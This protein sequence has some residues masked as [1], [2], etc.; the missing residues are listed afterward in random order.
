MPL[1]LLV[2]AA[3]LP[4]AQALGQTLRAAGLRIAGE[5]SCHMLVRDAVR[6]A[7]EAVAVLADTQD[8]T[9]HQAV[10]LLAGTA[11]LPVLLLGAQRLPSRPEVLAAIHG[12]LPGEADAPT[13]CDALRWADARFGEVQRLR[14]E[15]EGV[16]TRFNERKWV[17]RAKWLLLRDPQLDEPAA[18]ALL[19]AAA[20]QVNLRV[21]EVSRGLVEAALAADALNRA[22]QLRMLSQRLVKALA[23]QAGPADLAG[24]GVRCLT[25]TIQRAQANLSA[26]AAMPLT[27][28]SSALLAVADDC[29]QQLAATRGPALPSLLPSLLLADEH[30]EAMLLAA[31]ALAAA[32]ERDS[33]RPQ[34]QLVNLCGR[35]R[36]LSQRLVKQALIAGLLDSAGEASRAATHAADAA[37]TLQAFEAALTRLEQAPLGS[38]AIR[39]ALAQA[40]GQW[41][42]LRG[43]LAGAGT[44]AASGGLLVARESEALLGSF[45]ALTSLVE[46]SLQLL[47]G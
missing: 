40:R 17:D 2:V 38:A 32:L 21:G 37:L 19:R 22:G 30:A 39:A 41:Q 26:L 45:E 9:W 23:L 28:A 20:M 44:A 4:R 15:L 47:L 43:G 11:P 18:F 13:V 46:H 27:P 12:W 8:E 24:E 29:W 3:D 35:Q 33:G 1:S 42:R 25:D 6:L 7:P 10:E 34:L 14:A 16:R 31:D 36:M 5:S